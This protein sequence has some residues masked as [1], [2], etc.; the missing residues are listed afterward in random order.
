VLGMV[1][2][3]EGNYEAARTAFEQALVLEPNQTVA[4]TYLATVQGVLAEENA[5]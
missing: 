1:H 5:P 4:E 2:M 3:N